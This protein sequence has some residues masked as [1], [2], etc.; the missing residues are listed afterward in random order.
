MNNENNTTTGLR[1]SQLATFGRTIQVALVYYILAVVV[2]HLLQPEWSP[3]V[4]PMSAYVIGEGGWLMRFTFLALAVALLAAA[5]GIRRSTPKSFRSALGFAFMALGAV[6]TLVAGIF[7]DDGLPPPQLPVSTAGWVHLA[8][9]MLAFPMFL[10][11]P[12]FLTLAMR[13]SEHWA[14]WHRSLLVRLLLL[15]LAVAFFI[16]AAAPMGL[17]G[18]AQRLLFGVLFLWLLT[19]ARAFI[20]LAGRDGA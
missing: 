6:A 13:K 2:L 8:A 7:P 12:W 1:V 19:V 15:G 3:R 14:D 5:I 9:G 11:G 18:L 16:V 17:A 20:V 4:M 10:L